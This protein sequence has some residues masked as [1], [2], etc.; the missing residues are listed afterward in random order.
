MASITPVGPMD[1]TGQGTDS[2]LRDP[3]P[4]D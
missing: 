4:V 3:I 2:H 1:L